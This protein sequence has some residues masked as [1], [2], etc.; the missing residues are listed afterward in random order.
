[1]I[2]FKTSTMG[3]VL[4]R[5]LQRSIVEG[6]KTPHPQLE[7]AKSELPATQELLEATSNTNEPHLDLIYLLCKQVM[8]TCDVQT[9][10]F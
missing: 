7:F 4:D 3:Q 2:R 1:M 5:G 9:K 8:L 6:M 10:L